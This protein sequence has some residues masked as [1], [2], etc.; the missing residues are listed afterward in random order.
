LGNAALGK[1]FQLLQSSTQI[2]ARPHG[3]SWDHIESMLTIAGA[4]SVVSGSFAVVV[5]LFVTAVSKFISA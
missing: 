5:A 1:K 4:N 3:G 2:P